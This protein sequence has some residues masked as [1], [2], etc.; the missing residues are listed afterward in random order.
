VTVDHLSA[1]VHREHHVVNQT[2]GSRYP[3]VDADHAIVVHP[4][5]ASYPGILDRFCAHHADRGVD[6]WKLDARFSPEG[7]AEDVATWG[8][9]VAQTTRLPVF[10]VGSSRSA[11]DIYRALPVSEVFVG[12]VLIG[13][14][15]PPVLPEQLDSSLRQNTK[16]VLFILGENDMDSWPEV[17]KAAAAAAGPLEMHTH[18]D[19]V[20]RLLMNAEAC[21]DVVLEWC[22]RQLSNHLNPTWRFE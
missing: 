6:V 8:A 13:D 14:A 17:A 7:W 21:S 5:I 9:H 16:P 18:P 20:S 1:D 11:A 22:L 10:V 3:G 19:D 12:A 2:L 4:G 15:S